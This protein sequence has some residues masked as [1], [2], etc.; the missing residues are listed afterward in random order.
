MRLKPIVS[1]IDLNFK[2]TTKKLTRKSCYILKQ[3]DFFDSTDDASD[4]LQNETL[5]W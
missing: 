3:S 1:N 2:K 4:I 5:Y